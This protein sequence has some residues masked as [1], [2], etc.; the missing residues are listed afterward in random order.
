[1][2]ST[3]YKKQELLRVDP[4][5]NIVTVYRFDVKY[6][7]ETDMEEYRRLEFFFV[8]NGIAYSHAQYRKNEHYFKIMAG[9]ESTE[10]PEPKYPPGKIKEVLESLDK[11]KNKKKNK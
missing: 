9:I 8:D 10:I 6:Y 2:N 4:V 11:E 3:E 7:R 5:I 1:L